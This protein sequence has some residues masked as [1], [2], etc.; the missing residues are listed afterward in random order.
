[1]CAHISARSLKPYAAVSENSR[2]T[3]D[4]GARGTREERFGMDEMKK[5][6]RRMQVRLSKTGEGWR[7]VKDD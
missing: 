2:A 7:F 5:E 1:M 4:D 3:T 6:A